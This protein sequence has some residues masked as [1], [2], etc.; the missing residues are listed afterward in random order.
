MMRRWVLIGNRVRRWRELLHFHFHGRR[1]CLLNRTYKN[2]EQAEGMQ[3]IVAFS[4]WCPSSKLEQATLCQYLPEPPRLLNYLPPFVLLSLRG[5]ASSRNSSAIIV[6]TAASLARTRTD[7]GGRATTVIVVG[8]NTTASSSI[9]WA[10]ARVL[11]YDAAR[12]VGQVTTLCRTSEV[13][14]YLLILRFF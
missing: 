9:N 1:C 6:A 12:H 5:A 10:L 13:V 14:G 8:C 7:T 3:K 4:N 11:A 2:N